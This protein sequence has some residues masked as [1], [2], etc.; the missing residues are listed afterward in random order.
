MEKE[1]FEA[2]FLCGGSSP[3]REKGDSFV[4]M[5]ARTD[6]T[7][8][9]NNDYDEKIEMASSSIRELPII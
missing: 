3:L 5:R 2:D 7:P 8:K 1:N 4:C 6:E 9:H